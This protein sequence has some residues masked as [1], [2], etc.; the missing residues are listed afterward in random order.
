MLPSRTHRAATRQPGRAPARPHV[1]FSLAGTEYAVEVRH[2]RHLLFAPSEPAS[3]IRFL[4]KVYPILDLRRL[5]GLE[6]LAGGRRMLLLV[7]DEHHAAALLVDVVLNLARIEEEKRSPLPPVFACQ[8][9]RWFEG[10]A[11]IGDR[12][13][14]LVSV[15]GLLGA[16]DSRVATS[17]VAA[18]G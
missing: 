11:R 8:E 1:L 18:L 5:F 2:V 15:K 17:A 14:V 9:R 4:D 3:D 10:L 16:E 12:L 6:P 7:E 13:V